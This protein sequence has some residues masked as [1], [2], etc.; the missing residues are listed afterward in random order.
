MTKFNAGYKTEIIRVKISSSFLPRARCK[1]CGKGPSWYYYTRKPYLRADVKEYK[2]DS[3][4]WR[5]WMK[6]M[7]NDWYLDEQPSEFHSIEDFSL[8]LGD[9]H[10]RPQL[11][12]TR[13][14]NVPSHENVIEML[15][16]DCGHTTW[17]FNYK[18]TRNRPEI[19]NRK[20]RSFYPQKFTY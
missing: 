13:G 8:K 10:Y 6:H 11:H 5:N 3:K 9:I 12:R 16:C 20:S 18:S 19:Q 15:G 2:A 17:A 14:S 7:T 4:F 1:M